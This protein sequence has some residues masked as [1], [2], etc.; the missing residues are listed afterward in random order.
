[1]DE[2]RLKHSSYYMSV[3]DLVWVRFP[4]YIRSEAKRVTRWIFGY[5]VDH[6]DDQRGVYKV[7]IFEFD[8]E[9]SYF[10]NDI[11]ILEEKTTIYEN[12]VKK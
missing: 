1:M 5:I 7:H 9:A 4:Q 8:I 12:E 2:S 10:I 6:V 11:R 3:G